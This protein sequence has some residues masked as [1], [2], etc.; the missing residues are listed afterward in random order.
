MSDVDRLTGSSSDD[1]P[2]TV[3]LRQPGQA[4]QKPAF[5]ENVRSSVFYDAH[6]QQQQDQQAVQAAP[7]A[8]QA[9]EDTSA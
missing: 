7:S 3:Q 2:A 9:P 4:A 5:E 1:E 6:S 8:Q